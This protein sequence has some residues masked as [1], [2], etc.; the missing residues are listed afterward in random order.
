[1]SVGRTGRADA[2]R[3]PQP[4]VRRRGDRRPGDAPQRGLELRA[5][6]CGSATRSSSG[7]RAT[8]SRR[9]SRSSTR[10]A[11]APRPST[12][13]P[14]MPGLRR[15]RGDGR[16]RGH[17]PLHRARLS[18]AAPGPPP[19][20]RE[21]RGDG[22]RG[23]GRQARRA[24]RGVGPGEARG[25][26]LSPRPRQAHA[27]RAD[28]R[29]ERA[30]PARRA[31]A[32][33]DDPRSADSSTRSASATSARPPRRALAEHFRDVRALY[34]ADAERS[35]GSRTWG[36]RWPRSSPGSS[37][38]RR[39][40]KASRRCS[41]PGS[42]PGPPKTP[43]RGPFAGQDGGPHRDAGRPDPR[44]GE[45]GDGAARGEGVGQRVEEDR[46]PRRRRGGREQAQ[47]GE[48]SSG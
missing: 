7:A 41:P 29:E 37:P 21:P 35:P 14:T 42:G 8:S 47:E 20:L 38:S 11:P 15:R 48:P 30:E 19:A 5:R 39:T 31:R 4:G 2:G 46:L 25:R 44:A 10:S 34:D 1:M 23:P 28:G 32:R 12:S 6:T 3:R 43:P 36:P 18:G 27:A 33:Q 22:H 26:P 9:S 16:G 17:P 45:G 13:S 24:A 40:A